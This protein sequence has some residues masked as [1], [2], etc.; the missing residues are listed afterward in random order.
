MG[1]LREEVEGLD[2]LDFEAGLREF[3]EITGEGA[4]IAGEVD[5]AAGTVRREGLSDGL[6]QT[7]SGRVDEREVGPGEST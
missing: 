6:L 1:G 4:G 5:E 2:G 3:G 7:G